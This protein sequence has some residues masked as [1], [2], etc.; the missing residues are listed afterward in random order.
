MKGTT[1]SENSSKI[2]GLQSFNQINLL[3]SRFMCFHAR[4]TAIMLGQPQ[5]AC[6]LWHKIHHFEVK[7]LMFPTSSRAETFSYGRLSLSAAVT[8]VHQHWCVMHALHLGNWP[9][10]A[11]VLAWG[12]S[13]SRHTRYWWELT[14]VCT[15]SLVKTF[16]TR[17]VGGKVREVVKFGQITSVVPP[18]QIIGAREL[19]QT[20][21]KGINQFI[22]WSTMV[23]K[24]LYGRGEVTCKIKMFLEF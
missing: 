3:T 17:A 15:L 7:G 13:V 11:A 22:H 10:A 20:D 21:A 1:E 16:K 12:C 4:L 5:S 23:K 2:F 9:H 14:A 6:H 8:S 24:S 18:R 19:Q